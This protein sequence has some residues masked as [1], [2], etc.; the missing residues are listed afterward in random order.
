MTSENPVSSAQ[1]R[2]RAGVFKQSNKTHKTGR[3]RSKGEL[4]KDAKGRQEGVKSLS[5]KN[6]KELNRIARKNQITQQRK[7]N[8]DAV[9]EKKRNL[10][11]HNTPPFLVVVLPLSSDV[12][13][14]S[15]LDVLATCD[16][17]VTVDRCATS[18]TLHISIPRF[19]QRFCFIVPKYGN[20]YELLDAVKVADC[21][22]CVPS[23]QQGV[24]E[25]GEYCLSSLS[26]QGM[27]ASTFVLNGMKDLPIKKQNE[28]KKSI[29][30]SLESRF[31]NKKLHNLDSR[32]DGVLLLRNIGSQQLKTIFVREHRPHIY[33][34]TVTMETNSADSGRGTLL[35]SGY[36][37]SQALSVNALVH[38]P[39][40]GDF[41]MTK[42]EAPEDPHPLTVRNDK[43]V[44][45]AS[46]VDMKGQ[47]DAKVLAVANPDVQASLQSEVVPDPLDGEQTW[48]TEDELAEADAEAKQKKQSTS[49]RVPK[50]TSEYQAAWI[51]PESDDEG[52][53]DDDDE[54]SDEGMMDVP[55]EQQSQS[56]EESGSEEEEEEYETMTIPDEDDKYDADM[57]LDDE[58]EML[59]KYKAARDDEQ[60]P[61]EMDTPRE[62]PARTRFQKYRGLKSYRTSEWDPKENLPLDYSRIYQFGNF[63]RTRK[64][65][66]KEERDGEALPGRY[67]TVHIADVPLAFMEK[68]EAGQ[69]VVMFGL[70]P[71]EQRMSVVHF[72]IKRTASNSE[73]I[74][75]KE[76]MIFHAGYRRF[77]A[78][79]IY[80]QHT[81]A[82]KHKYER[83]LRSEATV[84]CTVYAPII[85]PVASVLMFKEQSNGQHELVG[86][87]SVMSVN[88]NRIITKRIVL[89]GHPLK[90][91]VK[92]AVIRYMFFNR[93]DIHWF[94]PVEMRTKHGRRGHIREPL[95]THGHM[96]V[97]F[98]KQLK[99]QDTVLMQLYKRVFPKW[100]YEGTLTSPESTTEVPS[101]GMAINDMDM[102][103][104]FD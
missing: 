25:Y 36:I 59:E 4:Q 44:N 43:R 75:S 99:S 56:D 51:L 72:T 84:V 60:F 53:D 2:H 61:D 90:I 1:A 73:P 98:D 5:K 13:C 50:G 101:S 28:S 77:A 24:D 57:N 64:R 42:I 14:K 85:F 18:G 19:K 83:F 71:N 102:Q 74:K 21:V 15:V 104:I 37:R 93:E 38:L 27:P 63:D 47:G 3:H 48:P 78:C 45:G 17:D 46:D 80:S 6:K 11:G 91:N 89:S 76:R 88:P 16:D 94:K 35:L 30:K 96:K 92:S 95:G 29:S 62:T 82:D 87:G 22:L 12:D 103:D 55:D 9:L 69:A 41:Q 34:E 39:G 68:Y 26:A 79:P 97:V 58:Q 40:W 32:Q 100:T 33:A 49:K 31:A 70:L 10:G 81:N 20:L 86:T 52:E 23:T 67:V 8:R 65:T 7:H 54:E 66:L